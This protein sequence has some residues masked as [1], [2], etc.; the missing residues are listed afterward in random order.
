[1]GRK[2]NG[3]PIH[4]WLIIDKPLGMSS[5]GVVGKIKR[6]TGAAKVGHGGTLDPLATGVLPIALGEATKTVSYAMDG[7]KAYEF[8]IRWGEQRSTDDAEGSVTGVSD[9]R[10]SADAMRAVAAMFVG[11][12]EQVPPIFSAIKVDGRRAYALARA[13]QEV[14]LKARTVTIHGLEL[15]QVIDNDHASFV[16]RCGK[17]TYMRA[18]ARDLALQLGTLGHIQRLRR[19]QVGPFTVAQALNPDIFDTMYADALLSEYLLPIETVL[20]DIPALALT[21]QEARRLRQGQGV[22]VLPIANRSTLTKIAQG[23]IVCAMAEG[24]LVA[25]ATIKGG[26]VR[27]LRVMN[28]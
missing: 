13:N 8:V 28:L 18:L 12:I 17:G 1:M 24:R 3:K 4:G 25:L 16:A 23:D 27:P 15:D 10:P 7:H 6:A 19:I 26:E 2:R 14:S 22:P 11:D 5:N 21:E 9:V 20:D